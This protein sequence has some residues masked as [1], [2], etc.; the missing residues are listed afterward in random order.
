MRSLIKE[1][2]DEGI[3]DDEVFT[4]DDASNKI[5]VKIPKQLFLLKDISDNDSFIDILVCQNHGNYR[6]RDFPYDE[7][8]KIKDEYDNDSQSNTLN[9]YVSFDNWEKEREVIQKLLSKVE[10]SIG[11]KRIERNFESFNTYYFSKENSKNI[12]LKIGEEGLN[13]LNSPSGVE[14][15]ELYAVVVNCSLFEL[16]KLYNTTG[17]TLFKNNVREGIT[18]GKASIKSI[19]NRYLNLEKTELNYNEVD[20]K[21]YSDYDSSLFWFSHNGITIFVDNNDNNDNKNYEFRY[22]TILLNP[23]ACSVINGAQTITNFFLVYSELKYAYRKEKEKIAK[24]DALIKKIQVKLTI[25]NGKGVYSTFITRG[26]NT[27]NPIGEE[28]FLAISSQASNINKASN[29]VIR[30]LKTGEPE[31]KGGLTSLQFIKYYLIVNSQPGTSKNFNKKN[32]KDK[33]NE[34]YNVLVEEVGKDKFKIKDNTIIEKM[35]F[36]PEI[37]EWWK[38]KN[39]K[40]GKRNR[41]LYDNYGKNYFESFVLKFYNELLDSEDVDARFDELYGEFVK[42]ISELGYDIS[43]NSFKDDELYERINSKYQ[44][45]VDAEKKEL[46]SSDSEEYLKKLEEYLKEA[47]PTSIQ[48]AILN[49]NKENNI[50]IDKVRV[51]RRVN[52]KIKEHFHLSTKTFNEIYQSIDIEQKLNEL[53]EIKEKEFPSFENSQLYHELNKGYNLYIVD[54]DD[55]GNINSVQ[56]KK[57]FD[58][59]LL[60]KKCMGKTKSLYDKTIMAF[61]NGDADLFPKSSGNNLHIRPKAQTKDDS[62]LFTNGEQLTKRTFWI[63]KQYIEKLLNKNL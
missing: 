17:V 26:L 14:K 2:I 49:Y 29:G 13:Y 52:G 40:K 5:E 16:K 6:V 15:D 45:Y 8:L 25:I 36:I 50:D 34:I 4:R 12:I 53:D 11:K 1:W 18:E 27:Q 3:I 10:T 62:F 33:L 46:K 31:R 30:I 55:K 28:D 9:I 54:M 21:E 57:E 19:F 48:N 39:R 41:T 7:I 44:E 59:K 56:F 35:A 58:F 42:I 60:D 20:S 37:E 32:G 63:S 47:N 22:D 24:L 38:Q 61:I 23:R 43:Y 51:I